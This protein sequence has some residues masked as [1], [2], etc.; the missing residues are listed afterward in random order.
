M[1]IRGGEN[2]YPKEIE[3]IVYQLPEIAEAAVVGR[4]H[5][6]YGEEPV[7]FVSLNTGAAIATDRIHDHIRESLSKFKRPAE[8]TILDDLPKNPVGKIDKPTLRRSIAEVRR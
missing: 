3:T 5:P 2:I 4:S 6:V 8:I 1:I 7:L